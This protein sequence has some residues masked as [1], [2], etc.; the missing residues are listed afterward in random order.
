MSRRV[1]TKVT[2]DKMIADKQMELILEPS[3][4]VTALAKEYAQQRGVRLVPAANAQAPG[5][6]FKPQPQE[7]PSAQEHS[8]SQLEKPVS[9]LADEK[10]AGTPGAPVTPEP[11]LEPIPDHAAVRKA[12]IAA[13]GYE[14]KNLDALISKVME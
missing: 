3:D 14:P 8:D 12:V 6:Q 7:I 11:A 1:I 10:V 2:V 4:I 13:V 5:G 9:E